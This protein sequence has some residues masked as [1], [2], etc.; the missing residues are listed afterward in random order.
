VIFKAL[1]DDTVYSARIQPPGGTPL[2]KNSMSI[3]VN[4]EGPNYLYINSE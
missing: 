3:S 4:P 1:E 2:G